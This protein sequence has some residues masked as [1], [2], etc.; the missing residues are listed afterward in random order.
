[1]IFVFFFCI[2]CVNWFIFINFSFFAHCGVIVLRF[3]KL[4]LTIHNNNNRIPKKVMKWF[5]IFCCSCCVSFHF[6]ISLLY[7][8]RSFFRHHMLRNA[9]RDKNCF[10]YVHGKCLSKLCVMIIII[11]KTNLIY[12]VCS[13]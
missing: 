10:S 2:V 3:Y 8:S 4:A 11:E 1:M 13:N 5:C 7:R 9:Q 6:G 12:F